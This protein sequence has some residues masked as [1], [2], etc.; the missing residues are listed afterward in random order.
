[1]LS[2]GAENAGQEPYMIVEMQTILLKPKSPKT[3]EHHVGAVLAAF[4]APS[5]LRAVQIARAR[6]VLGAG[7]T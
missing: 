5:R 4:D 6:G 1:M 2:C 7:Q 3:V